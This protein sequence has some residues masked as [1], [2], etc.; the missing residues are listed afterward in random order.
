M[1]LPGYFERKKINV[2]NWTDVQIKL[3]GHPQNLIY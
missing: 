2:E 3:I 1:N